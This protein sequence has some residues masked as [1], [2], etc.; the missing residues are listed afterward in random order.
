MANHDSE[1][2]SELDRF[3]PIKPAVHLILLALAQQERHGY[4]IIQFVNQHAEG[5]VRLATGPLYRH[6]HRLLGSGLVAET[7]PPEDETVDDP[8]RRYY[9][10]TQLGSDVLAAEKARLAALVRFSESIGVG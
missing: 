7:D 2:R 9:R 5:K 1:A 4:A 10:L 3:L 8:R 6:L